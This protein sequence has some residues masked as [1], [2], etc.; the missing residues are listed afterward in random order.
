ML[1][2]NMYESSK[3]MAPQRMG[4]QPGTNEYL[5]LDARQFHSSNSDLHPFSTKGNWNCPY[6]SR[7]RN[8]VKLGMVLAH[9]DQTATVSL[10]NEDLPRLLPAKYLSFH[11]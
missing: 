1:S 2:E 10:L 8:D 5:Q 6:P 4:P 9:G 7:I 3:I 11:P